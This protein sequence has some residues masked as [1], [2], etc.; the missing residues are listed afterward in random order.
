MIDILGFRLLSSQALRVSGGPCG[1]SRAIVS[2]D[3]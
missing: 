3:Y 2:A 1:P